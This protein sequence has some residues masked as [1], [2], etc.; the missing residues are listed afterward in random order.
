VKK[1]LVSADAQFRFDPSVIFVALADGSQIT[2]IRAAIAEEALA[3][4]ER[5]RRMNLLEVK[6]LDAARFSIRLTDKGLLVIDRTIAKMRTTVEKV[7]DVNPK[8]SPKSSA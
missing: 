1:P 8:R 5:L 4:I 3:Y 7:R 6:W 2:C